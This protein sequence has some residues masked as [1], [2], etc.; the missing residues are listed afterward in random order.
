MARGK[1]RSRQSVP[2]RNSRGVRESEVSDDEIDSFHAQRDKILLDDSHPAKASR[3][4]SDPYDAL[5]STRNVLDVVE[6]AESSDDEGG[7]MDDEDSDGEVASQDNDVGFILS[8]AQPSGKGKAKVHSESSDKD[9]EDSESEQEEEF[10][11]GWGA[12]KKSYYNT[13][14]LDDLESDSEMDEDEKRAME[15]REVKK[16]QQR[17]RQGMV[18]DDFGIGSQEADAESGEAARI[19]RR[20]DLDLSTAPN[21]IEDSAK[22]AITKIPHNPAELIARVQRDTPET[23][24]LIGE[25]ADVVDDLNAITNRMANLQTMSPDHPSLG[26]LHV[27]HQTLLTYVTT[28]IFYFY[29]RANSNSASSSNRKGVARGSMNS[30]IERLA[31][32]KAGLSTLE[33]FGLGADEDDEGSE[34]GSTSDA[35]AEEGKAPV[36][37]LFKPASMLGEDSSAEE[38]SQSLGSLEEDELAQLVAEDKEN[39]TVKRPQD[40]MATSITKPDNKGKKE[41][42]TDLKRKGKQQSAVA[43]LASVASTLDDGEGDLADEMAPLS[44]RRKQIS[45]PAPND[46]Y[47]EPTRLETVDQA[48]KEAIR[49]SL[50][51]HTGQLDA[52]DSGSMARKLDGDLD[53]PYRDK[54]RSRQSVAA[55]NANKAAKASGLSSAHRQLDADDFG[56]DDARDWRDVMDVDGD[57]GVRSGKPGAVAKNDEDYYDLITSS[58]K[59][60]KQTKK[61]QHDEERMASRIAPSH[62]EMEDGEH[63]A[64]N[65]EIEKNRGLTPRRPKASRNPRVKKRIRYEKAQKKLSSRGPVYKGGQ[66][67]L[68]G[69]YG[70]ES[71]GISSNVVKSRQFA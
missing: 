57:L 43:P 19:Q 24:A 1:G 65:R 35:S 60:E 34:A 46:V 52:R 20:N 13:N 58:R 16:L 68:Q 2:D 48:D 59:S 45:T 50:K 67:A 36:S 51:F 42:K 30:I 64:I 63:R 15:L 61:A 37:F 38:D 18:D 14:N 47:S 5:A 9:S 4:Q 3:R 17:S 44:K 25:F 11:G 32:L 7:D 10:V 23:I 70:G 28:L 39:A 29:V 69:G 12:N 53:N 49:R 8:R 41:K 26:L 27:H 33:G 40:S 22:H 54:D 62:A 6:E 66:A 21:I 31:K 71:S 56:E 55:T